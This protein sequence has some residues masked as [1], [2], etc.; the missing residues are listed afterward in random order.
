VQRRT[1][2]ILLAICVIAS[3]LLVLAPGALSQGMHRGNNTT[4]TWNIDEMYS[5][6]K[7]TGITNSSAS[8]DIQNAVI[9]TKEG[10]VATMDFAKPL[11]GQ[12]FFANNTGIINMGDKM[13]N[14]TG[15]KHKP[16]MGDYSNATIKVAGASAVM[17]KKNITV[18]KH[19]KSG[20]EFQFTGLSVYLP[21]GTVKSY[22]LSTPVKVTWSKDSKTMKVVGSPELK[23][24]IQD[25]LK[26]GATFSA[27][28]APVS[29]KTIDSK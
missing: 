16:V 12:Y 27:T 26:G 19:D 25:A 24:D 15:G 17:V 4:K 29:L 9:K 28:A 5:A 20:F 13:G 14:Q 7:V 1:I 8:Y 22:K 3:L 11:S 23:T 10:K 6:I 18:T 21:D 2:N